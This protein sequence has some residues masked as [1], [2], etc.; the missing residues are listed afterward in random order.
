ME[1]KGCN[2]FIL[3]FEYILTSAQGGNILVTQISNLYLHDHK[4]AFLYTQIQ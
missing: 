4:K 3:G 2:R 1:C